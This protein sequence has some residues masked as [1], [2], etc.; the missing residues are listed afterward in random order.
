MSRFAGCNGYIKFNGNTFGGVTSISF[1]YEG[2]V[3]EATGMDSGGRREYVR[4]RY[5]ASW[6]ASGHYETTTGEHPYYTDIENT[7]GV[8]LELG[9]GSAGGLKITA[10]GT[11]FAT[12]LDF[13]DTLDGLSDWTMR[14]VIAGTAPTFGTTT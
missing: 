14:G 13:T 12:G 2:D 11:A 1:D 7:T 4:G 6:E 3:P 5:R 9:F 10:S 8:D